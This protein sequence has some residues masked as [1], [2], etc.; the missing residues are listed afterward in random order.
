MAASPDFSDET[1]KA[2]VS[3]AMQELQ[4]LVEGAIQHPSRPLCRV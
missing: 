4:V 3:D 1:S 2:E